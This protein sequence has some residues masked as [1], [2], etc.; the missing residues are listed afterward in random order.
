MPPS[1]KAQRYS[2]IPPPSPASRST[3]PE[4]S[5]VTGI[6]ARGVGVLIAIAAVGPVLA[7]SSAPRSLAAPDVRGWP[8]TSVADSPAVIW[9]LSIA[10]ASARR[11]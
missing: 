1:P 4:P 8:S 9:P 3:E 7:N 2:A 11:W 5:N 6:E 10:G